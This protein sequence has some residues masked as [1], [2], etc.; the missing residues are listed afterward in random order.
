[1]AHNWKVGDKALWG[2]MP[3]HIVTVDYVGRDIIV[4]HT[5]HGEYGIDREFLTPI[6]EPTCTFTVTCGLVEDGH[7][8]GDIDGHWHNFGTQPASVAT[9]CRTA[10]E[11]EGK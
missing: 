8:D 4:G 11:S 5:D 3:D 9:A 1:M 2:L 6:P 7:G 10:L